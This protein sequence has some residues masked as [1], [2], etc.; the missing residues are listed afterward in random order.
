M[1]IFKIQILCPQYIF[2][3]TFF[4]EVEL[5]TINLHTCSVQRH[6]LGNPIMEGVVVI[7]FTSIFRL[8]E[9]ESK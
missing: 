5:K 8:R 7:C 2:I 3:S 9:R 6:K 1:Y 4:L